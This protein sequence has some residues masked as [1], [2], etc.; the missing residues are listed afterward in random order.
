MSG[1]IYPEFRSRTPPPP[2]TISTAVTHDPEQSTSMN[3]NSAVHADVHFFPDTPPPAY[4]FCS[5]SSLNSGT[6]LSGHCPIS[7]RQIRHY[8]TEISRGCRE[9]S[10]SVSNGGSLAA[11]SVDVGFADITARRHLPKRLTV[12]SKVEITRSAMPTKIHRHSF[13]QTSELPVETVRA[14]VIDLF[15]NER[16]S[17]C[18]NSRVPCSSNT[19]LE[20]ISHSQDS[21]IAVQQHSVNILDQRFQVNESTDESLDS[22]D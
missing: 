21:F 13:S 18:E 17:G 6:M 8:N 15:P 4:R 22:V 16:R 1:V 7:T 2:Y 10:A 3:L 9:I 19:D 5:G 14:S 11:N 20:S 12:D